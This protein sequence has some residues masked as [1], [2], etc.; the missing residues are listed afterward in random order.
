M[1]TVVRT[2]TPPETVIEAT[3][4]DA[5]Q[6]TND[7]TWIHVAG[8]RDFT[9][10]ISGING[11]TVQLH[12]SNDAAAPNNTDDAHQLG[13]NITADKIVQ[14]SGCPIKWLKASI[15]AYSAGTITVR[16]VARA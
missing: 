7:G 13:S 6:A 10:D 1:V 12:G 4:L 5:L 8:M 15:P 9:L 3:L 11:D 14:L 2:L 16:V